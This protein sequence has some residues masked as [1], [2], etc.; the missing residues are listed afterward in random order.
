MGTFLLFQTGIGINNLK[1][2]NSIKY[3]P[4]MPYFPKVTY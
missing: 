3:N 2:N 4:R 1:V